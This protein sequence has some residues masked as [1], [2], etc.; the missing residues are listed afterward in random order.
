MKQ[1]EDDVEKLAEQDNI[2][3]TDYL[4]EKEHNSMKVGFIRGY[5]K[6]KETLYTEEDMLDVFNFLTFGKKSLTEYK[7]FI[8]SLKQPK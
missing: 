4:T 6:A 3:L 2:T 1:I 5:N 7:D 8:Q